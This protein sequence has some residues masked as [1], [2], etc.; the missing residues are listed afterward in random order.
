MDFKSEAIIAGELMKFATSGQLYRG[1]KPIMWSVVERTALAEAEIEYEIV[2]SDTIWTGFPIQTGPEFLQGSK[3]V[4]WTTTPWTIPANRCVC[5]SQDVSYGLY[6]VTS[7]E[8]DFG[9]QPGDKFVFADNLAQQCSEKAKVTLGRNSDVSANDLKGM[10]LYHPLRGMGVDGYQFL[11]PMLQGDHVTDEAGTGFVHTAPGHGRDDFENWVA[12]REEIEAL[13]ISSAIPFCVADDGSFT[14]DAPGFPGVRVM[15]DKGKKGKANQAVI[16][17]LIGQNNLF[18]RGR[19]KHD[20]PHSWRSKKPI[21]FRNTPQWFVHMDKE[22]DGKNHTLRDV[23]LKAIDETRFV[24]A[25]GQNRLRAM[26]EQRPDWVLSRQ[27]AWGVPICVFRNPETG[28]I[29]PG[30]D[31]TGTA[32]LTQRIKL[33]FEADGADA[34]YADGAKE[35]FLEGF[36]D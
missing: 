17:A 25:A 36:V 24:P 34:W 15:D 27:R 2:E 30:P 7:A 1:S 18:A 22:I 29:A 3:V 21:I 31:F 35:R 14:D 8:N 6:E 4:I 19:I 9:P 16:T 23:S 13:G 32:E 20:Y 26:I 12:K 33:A 5:Y 28:Q 10:V 11:V